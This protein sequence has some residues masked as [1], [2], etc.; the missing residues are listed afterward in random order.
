MQAFKGL[1]SFVFIGLY[2]QTA[3][4]W[5]NM[6]EEIMFVTGMGKDF[7]Q[8]EEKGLYLL[9]EEAAWNTELS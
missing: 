8:E 6:T 5:T 3:D 7:E 1:L 9:G 4:S 2:Y